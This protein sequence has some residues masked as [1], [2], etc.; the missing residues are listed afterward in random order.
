MKSNYEW[1][2]AGCATARSTLVSIRAAALVAVCMGSAAPALGQSGSNDAIISEIIVTARRREESLD[3]VPVSATVLTAEVM[4]QRGVRD[5]ADLGRF[6]PNLTFDQGTGNTG[7]S[8]NAQV[9]IRGVGQQD[10][11]FTTD[12]GV[13]MYVDGVYFPRALGAI[14]DL[15]DID[16]VEVLRGPQG[17]LF[18][19]NTIGGA[20]NIVS[21]PP[22][23]E[24]SAVIEGTLGNLERRDIRAVVDLPLVEGKLAAKV[25]V[26]SRSRDGLTKR[27]E[28]G[29]LGNINRDGA[30]AMLR[31]NASDAVT[32]RLSVD[33]TRVREEATN[34]RLV[35]VNPQAPVLSLWN[36]LVGLPQFGETWGSQFLT[37][38]PW[39]SHAT[40]PS[41]SDLDLKGASATI[42]WNTGPVGVKLI[43]AWRDQ[44]AFFASDADHSPLPYLHQSVDNQYRM[45]SE[46]L[47][48]S[49]RAIDARLDRLVGAFHLQENGTDVFE[50]PL[51]R[52]LYQ[53]LS[54]LPAALIPLAPYPTG[55]GGLPLFECPAAPAGFPCA[56]G[57][58]NPFNVALD[59]DQM[60]ENRIDFASYAL[61]VHGTYKLT[62]KLSVT[63]GGRYS[64]DEKQ[65][66][67]FGVRRGSN[68]IS[69][70]PMT[71][72]RSWNAFTPK[73]SIEYQW[74]DAVMTY[75]SV[76]KGFKSGG[77]N[78]RALSPGEVESSFD[79]EKT[80]AWEVGYKGLLFDRRLRLNVALFLTEYTDIQLTTV[81][82]SAEGAV[83]AIV[84]NAGKA[85]IKGVEVEML[86]KPARGYELNLGVGYTDAKY[87][88]LNPG[89]TAVTLDS[90]FAKTP[91]WSVDAGAQYRHAV[92]S[93]LDVVL[94]GDYSF[95]SKVYHQPSNIELLSADDTGLLS[96][97]IGVEATDGKWR[98]SIVGSNLT[99]EL[100]T[101]SGIEALSSLGSADVI[102]GQP[103]QYAVEGA[104]RF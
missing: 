52:G 96:A 16:R 64:K 97:R 104:W 46:E 13:G 49:G 51:A 57:A 58:G 27:D 92:S 88:R 102:Y 73:G 63:G 82:A 67:A 10:F 44:D 86:A 30:Q 100:Y 26:L 68:T 29:P 20:I 77:F 6:V 22:G 91:E 99:D 17:T 61:F 5:A 101:V 32:V 23:D 98:M 36:L 28:G 72:S 9:F 14:L 8:A 3:R 74:T 1:P 45:H 56:G 55:P 11:L 12:P 37:E 33:Y 53:G 80:L 2:Y 62:D 34:L 75:A 85:R 70:P 71:V 19:K 69:V 78:G 40:G 65:L 95:R 42:E 54:S 103:R 48:L 21:R 39:R 81:G 43:T 47:Q 76:S 4:Q 7:G 83:L 31:W 38:D 90:K 15:V 25:A 18:G 93:S 35:G 59:I 24:L 87:T 60:R 50:F 79:P 84:D 94:R 66:Y 89:V 41:R